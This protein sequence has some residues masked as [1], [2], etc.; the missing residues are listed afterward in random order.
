[1]GS[2]M[3]RRAGNDRY[4]FT[5]FLLLHHLMEEFPRESLS[6]AAGTAGD[7]TLRPFSKPS[8]SGHPEREEYG[9]VRRRRSV[10][11]SLRSLGLWCDPCDL[12]YFVGF[13]REAHSEQE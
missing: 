6:I 2:G 5:F 7:F 3:R 1:M 11:L 4:P 12:G 9:G 10:S 13:G 8:R